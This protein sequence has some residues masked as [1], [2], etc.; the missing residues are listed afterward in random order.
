MEVIERY[1][2]IFAKR[3]LKAS[4]GKGTHVN[5]PWLFGFSN[6][7]PQL[8]SQI[9]MTEMIDSHMHLEVLPSEGTLRKQEDS[10]IIDENVHL[11]N[12]SLHPFSELVN[13]F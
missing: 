12:M 11:L 13:C 7:W 10:G 5:N 2:N 6:Q 1:G 8:M 4:M 3:Q 9:K